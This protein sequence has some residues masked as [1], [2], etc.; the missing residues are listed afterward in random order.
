MKIA[1]HKKNEPENENIIHVK[2][3]KHLGKKRMML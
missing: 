2:G 3:E 1:L